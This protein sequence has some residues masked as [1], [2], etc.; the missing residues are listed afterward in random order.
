MVRIVHPARTT[1]LAPRLQALLR[2]HCGKDLFR[3]DEN[4]IG[5][6]GTELA[7]KIL[8]ARPATEAERPTFKPLLGRSIPRPDAL[9]SMQAIGRDVR[10]ALKKPA[11]ISS[12]LSGPWPHI[13][14]VYLRDLLIGADPGRLRVLMDRILELTPKLTWSV[15]A[16]SALF[17]VR[18]KP[19]AS[20]IATSCTKRCGLC[21]RPG[22]S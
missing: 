22:T 6:A 2:N 20:S 14:H 11:L 9:K 3:I 7:D 13:G 19:E 18:L 12:D 16:A 17:P 5:I 1:L 21:H 4:T 8:S 15:I 10:S